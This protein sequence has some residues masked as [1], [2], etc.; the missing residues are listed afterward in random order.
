MALVSTWEGAQFTPAGVLKL[1]IPAAE[2]A[3]MASTVVVAFLRESLA[4]LAPQP[5]S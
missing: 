3:G 2:S 5:A 4:A 1:P